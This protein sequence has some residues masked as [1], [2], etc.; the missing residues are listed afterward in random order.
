MSANIE[1]GKIM[2]ELANACANWRKRKRELEMIRD[3]KQRKISDIFRVRNPKPAYTKDW[4]P[5]QWEVLRALKKL[6]HDDAWLS[7]VAYLISDFVDDEVFSF[8]EIAEFANDT[9]EKN[10]RRFL[11]YKENPKTILVAICD[12]Y[13]EAVKYRCTLIAQELDASEFRNIATNG[14]IF[15]RNFRIAVKDDNDAEMRMTTFSIK[16]FIPGRGL[17]S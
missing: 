5:Y 8:E 17:V 11:L 6:K 13:I 4:S 15:Q 1:S 2:W 16:A 14:S 7:N 3:P 10:G 9:S 12:S